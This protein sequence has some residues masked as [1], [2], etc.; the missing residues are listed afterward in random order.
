MSYE[1]HVHRRH[2][3]NFETLEEAQTRARN[4]MR[5]QPDSEPEI[6]DSTTKRAVEPAS[7][8]SWRED[9]SNKIGY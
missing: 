5:E 1:L 8:R 6:L 7:S 2:V 4:L 9:L 3:A